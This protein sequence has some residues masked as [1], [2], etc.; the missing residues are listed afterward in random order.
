MITC[1]KCGTLVRE[2]EVEI[3]GQ[4]IEGEAYHRCL[5]MTGVQLD[6]LAREYALSFPPRVTPP[7]ADHLA[8]WRTN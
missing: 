8:S 7:I 4:A 1:S 6:R 3:N 5:R 2:F